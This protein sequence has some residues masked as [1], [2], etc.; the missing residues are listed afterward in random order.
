VNRTLDFLFWAVMTA[1]MIALL[2]P[3]I[4]SS[5]GKEKE[6]VIYKYKQYEFIDLS[7][8]KVGGRLT[9][10]GDISVKQRERRHFKRELFDRK[11]FKHSLARDLKTLR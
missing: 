4:A 5:D 1:V 2:A 3:A 7:N 10:P 8:M 9:A 6:S 11:H